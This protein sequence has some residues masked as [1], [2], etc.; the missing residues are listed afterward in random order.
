MKQHKSRIPYQPYLVSN[1]WLMDLEESINKMKNSPKT[2]QA[3]MDKMEGERIMIERIRKGSPQQNGTKIIKLLT[4]IDLL[5]LR[6]QKEKLIEVAYEKK[7]YAFTRHYQ[8]T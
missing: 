6:E 5:L 7:Q 2:S 1:H 8:L 4:S 3:S